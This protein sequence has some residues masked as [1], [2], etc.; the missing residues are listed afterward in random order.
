MSRRGAG[1]AAIAIATLLAVG[2]C[3]SGLTPGAASQERELARLRQRLLELERQSAV[4]QAELEHLRGRVAELESGGGPAPPAAEPAGGRGTDPRS[5][6]AA[7]REEPVEPEIPA[8][9]EEDDLDPPSRSA[10]ASEPEETA[11]ADAGPRA[12]GAGPLGPVSEAARE[13]YDRGYTLY[14]Q[15]RYLDAESTFQRFLQAWPRTDLSDNALYWI[16]ESRFGRGDYAGAMSAFRECAE[17]YPEGNKV[18]DAL[19]KVGQSLE[20][21][22]DAGGARSTYDELLRRFPDSAAAVSAAE[23]RD[24]LR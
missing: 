22:G 18:P 21:L 15:G 23:L 16:G 1:G 20:R 5:E 10:A 2:G 24:A 11:G 13:L 4:A 8:R 9:L 14:H 17:R 6:S 3:A 19:L 7:P 12:E